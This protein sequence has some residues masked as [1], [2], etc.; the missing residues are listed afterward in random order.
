M[1][2]IVFV[3]TSLCLLAQSEQ[4]PAAQEPQASSAKL[5]AN[6]SDQERR[7]EGLFL[8]RCSLCHLPQLPTHRRLASDL[9]GLFAGADTEK[10]QSIREVISKGVP[11]MMPGFQYGLSAKQFDD[12]ISYL[13]AS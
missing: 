8:Q 7:G 11:T 5:K 3:V 1:V 4:A 6:F 9:T 12:L 13:K 2:L 10:E